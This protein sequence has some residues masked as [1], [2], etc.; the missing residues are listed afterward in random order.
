M[1]WINTLT[2]PW[3]LVMAA[4][5]PAVLS[6][7][8]LK[9]RRRPIT[10][11][12]T[13]LWRRALEDLHVNSIWQRL[14]NNILLWLQ[15]L[16]LLLAILA[17]LRPGWQGTDSVG[18]RRVYLI[19][20]SAS[21]QTDEEGSSRLE[22][23][24][25]QVRN[26]I[27]QTGSDD[28]G[29]VIA[30][31]D[32]ADVRQG[33]TK[34][35]NKLLSAVQSIEPTQRTTDISEALRAAAGLA[36][37]GRSSFD[38]VGDIQVADA[39]PAKVFVM[40]DGAFSGLEEA[41]LGQLQVEYVPIGE[42]K[43]PNVAILSFAVQRNDEKQNAMEAFAR[44]TN[45]GDEPVMCTASLELN[46]ELAD[47]N[48]IAIEPGKETALLF[49]LQ[50]LEQGDLKLTLDYED[51]L[52]IDNVA[53]AAI[54]PSRRI[55][56]LVLTPGN[57]ALE[58]ALQTERCQRI[59]TVQ[60]ESV[61]FLA[62]LEASET[63]LSS[64]Y[65]L[66]LFDQCAPKKMPNANTLFLGTPP[67]ETEDA[68]T[69]GWTQGPDD[70]PLFI[71]DVNRQNPI[72]QYLEMAS[73]TIFE[74]HTVTPPEGGT[75]L[76]TSNNG[77]IFAVAP[78]G[79]FQDAV[80][81]FSLVENSERG[82]EINTDWGRKR[83][84][85]VFIYSVIEHLGGGITEATA[86]TVLPGQ[87]IGLTLSNRFD[88]YRVESPSGTSYPL[89]RNSES[90]LTFTRTDEL[91]S[92]RVYAGEETEPMETFCVNLF[93]PQESKLDVMEGIDIGGNQ[94]AATGSVIQAR[95]EIWRWLLVVGLILL[96]AEWVVFN[97]RIFA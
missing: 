11:S 70:G 52:M 62:K 35:K 68:T 94:I 92:Y 49:D 59:A 19:D 96:M 75:V 14:R 55:S 61:D 2:W 18:E 80:M 46:G 65:D 6:L 63:D 9:L 40:S 30:F 44:I 84:F 66:I 25:E 8:F 13:L 33:F 88:S 32:R 78:R 60:V 86:P 26:L 21:M 41:D 20:Q 87:A 74:G 10:V 37:P 57:S 95:Q 71:L 7:Y 27:S 5:P 58:A 85:P 56:V 73:V 79:P 24:K 83:S 28:V 64:P 38:K 48:E 45:F 1:N 76:M 97:R 54:R 4:I 23:A 15:L 12:S 3:W 16:F 50:Q 43:T 47:A 77:P 93:S 22:K 51:P 31:S 72:T 81:G 82:L 17:C 34:D 90:R 36:N 91:G 67:P 42:A 69:K 53:Y 89:E 29:M 39:I